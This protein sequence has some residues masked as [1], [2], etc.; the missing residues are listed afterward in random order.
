MELEELALNPLRRSRNN[1]QHSL[2]IEEDGDEEPLISDD[3]DDDRTDCKNT[4]HRRWRNQSVYLIGCLMEAG[5]LLA[6]SKSDDIFCIF[7]KPHE[8]ARNSNQ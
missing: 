4:H 8:S 6:W 5:K 2:L 7:G 1:R 3:D